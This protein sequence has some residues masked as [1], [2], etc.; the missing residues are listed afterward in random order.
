MEAVEGVDAVDAVDAEE[1]DEPDVTSPEEGVDAD[2]LSSA[3][4]P[5]PITADDDEV[6]DDE[7]ED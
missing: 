3:T 7:S 6:A 4:L 1:P 5:E 2:E